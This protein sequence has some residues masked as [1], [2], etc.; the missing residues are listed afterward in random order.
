MCTTKIKKHYLFFTVIIFSIIT[1]MPAFSAFGGGTGTLSNP[2][3]IWTEKHIYELHDSIMQQGGLWSIMKAF[4]LMQNIGEHNNNGTDSVRRMI[5]DGSQSWNGRQAFHGFFFGN[6]HT[7]SLAVNLR[8]VLPTDWNPGTHAGLFTYTNSA[9][10]NNLTVDGYIRNDINPVVTGF[11]G[12]GVGGIVGLAVYSEFVNCVNLADFPG[13]WVCIGGIAR[14]SAVS[15][16]INCLNGKDVTAFSYAGG[17][18]GVMCP[19]SHVR[20]CINIGTVRA[21]GGGG[22]P[23]GEA[24]GI[25]GNV[26]YVSDG[27]GLTANNWYISHSINAGFVYGSMNTGGIVGSKGHWWTQYNNAFDGKLEHCL[28]TGVLDGGGN[29][30]AIAAF[31]HRT[32]FVNNHYDKQMCIYRGLNNNDIFGA[33]EGHLTNEITGTELQ[34]RLQDDEIWVYRD[35]LYPTLRFHE[36]HPIAM[37]ARSPAYLD[38]RGKPIEFDRHNAITRCFFVNIE[39]GVV[40]RKAFQCV[41]IIPYSSIKDEVLLNRIG[42]DTLYSGIGRERKV[43]PIRVVQLIPCRFILTLE[44]RP[45]EAA[46]E[47]I[48]EGEYGENEVAPYEIIVA[49][50]YTFQRWTYDGDLSIAPASLELR[51]SIV[52]DKSYHLVAMLTRDSFNLVTR[53]EPPDGGTTTGDGRYD[54]HELATYTAVPAHCYHFLHWTDEAT[55]EIISQEKIDMIEMDRDYTLVANFIKYDSFGLVLKMNLDSAGKLS[56]TDT[57][58]FATFTVVPNECYRFINWTD[59][60]TGAV[61]SNKLHDTIV[62]TKETTLIANFYYGKF[63]LIVTANPEDGGSVTGNGDYPCNEFAVFTAEPAVCYTFKNWTNAYTNEVISVSSI[64]SIKMTQDF[65]IVANFEREPQYTLTVRSNP[66]TGGN[67]DR[68][69]FPCSSAVYWVEPNECYRF[70]NWTDEATGEVVS[71]K[72]LDTLWHLTE[73]RT[74]IANFYYGEFELTVTANPAD[75]SG[76]IVTGTGTY[77]CNAFAVFTATPKDCW[78]FSHWT[79]AVTGEQI[80]VATID[81]LKMTQDLSII[82]HFKADNIYTLTVQAKPQAGGIVNRN[83]FGCSSVVFI[84][85]PNDCYI[86]LNWT[87]AS[88]GAVV[89][90]KLI[91]TLDLFSDR[92]FIANYKH[93]EDYNFRIQS[94]LTLNGNTLPSNYRYTLGD[95][96]PKLKVELYSEASPAELRRITDFNVS[97][98]YCNVFARANRSS[99]K[100]LNGWDITHT[101]VDDFN[102]LLTTYSLKFSNPAGLNFSNRVDLFEMEF[103]MALPTVNTVSKIE[104]KHYDFVLEPVFTFAQGETECLRLSDVS[105]LR[106]N[107]ICVIDLLIFNVSDTDFSLQVAENNVNYSIGF[108]CDATLTIYNSLGQAVYVP[109]SGAIT[110]GS[111]SLDLNTLNL[112]SGSYFF[113]LVVAGINRKI[114]G[115]VIGK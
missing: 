6:D 111:Y 19:S 13:P 17:I 65:R 68:S 21:I 109:V 101:P 42:P 64:D 11:F 96:P 75:S 77:P 49:Q 82:G 38:D 47:L 50:C 14:R 27:R 88:S 18:I 12:I 55:G 112:S 22:R 39:N 100:G 72:L 25:V 44:S 28:N 79:N 32:T 87:D 5:G 59:E 89:S 23:V 63:E 53:A 58:T 34:T 7:I 60:E 97:F 24:G 35:N 107:P 16:F 4:R 98:D 33:A 37:I 110:K 31:T 26:G 29:F 15:R 9:F 73:D 40:W 8:D 93:F 3:Q 66:S 103:T 78:T 80:S 76:G 91:D 67:A 30:G 90:E 52:M 45:P 51:D 70:I 108:D 71:D 86:F 115:V 57:C 20:Q 102:N 10:V 81:S 62:L 92:T 114:V 1:T 99:F 56:Q 113:E 41:D 46:I 104:D 61:V 48:G 84:T 36:H 69:Y 54:C 43:V 95:N 83:H 94:S 85:E 74:F 105:Q 106:V 2:Y